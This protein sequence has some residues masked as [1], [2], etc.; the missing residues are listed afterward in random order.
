MYEQAIAQRGGSVA[1]Q[2]A[3]AKGML[4]AQSGGSVH[5][6]EVDTLLAQLEPDAPKLLDDLTRR[7]MEH[8]QRTRGND[9]R[10]RRLDVELAMAESDDR[11]GTIALRTALARELARC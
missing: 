8:V 1:Q 5:G 2:A 10:R 9:V 4:Q 7:A 11:H 6:I 3:V